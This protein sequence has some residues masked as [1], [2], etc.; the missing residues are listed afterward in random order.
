MNYT[1][2][3]LI[4]RHLTFLKNYRPNQTY[5]SLRTGYVQVLQTD[6]ANILSIQDVD[7]IKSAFELLKMNTSQKICIL[8]TSSTMQLILY[9][10]MKEVLAALLPKKYSTIRLRRSQLNFYYESQSKNIGVYRFPSIIFR[11]ERDND[12]NK[13]RKQPFA[14]FGNVLVFPSDEYDVFHFFKRLEIE[15]FQKRFVKVIHHD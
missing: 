8:I 2:V 4:P 13:Y 14:I 9:D 3:H 1:N 10:D 5:L 12:L 7:S 11:E 6:D 15:Q